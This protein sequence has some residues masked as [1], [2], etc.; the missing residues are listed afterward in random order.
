MATILDQSFSVGKESTYGTAVALAR[1]YEVKADG[2]KRQQESLPSVGMR[3]GMQGE[4]SDRQKTINMGGSGTTSWGVLNKGA[5]APVP[6]HVRVLV[7]PDA[8]GVDDGVPA[9]V[10][11]HH[12]GTR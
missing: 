11:H 1:A 6:G 9:D 10:R 2:W 7:G 12:G 3:P 4:G 5:G 8:A